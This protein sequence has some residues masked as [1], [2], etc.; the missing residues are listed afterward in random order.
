MFK[1]CN[2][3]YFD[4]ILIQSKYCETSKFVWSNLED[5]IY[6]GLINNTW[7]EKECLVNFTFFGY[8]LSKGYKSFRQRR[9]HVCHS[10]P[11]SG[12]KQLR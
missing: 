7:V 4:R 10:F 6:I 3:F 5:A 1:K 8:P 12:P 2:L 9:R 11:H